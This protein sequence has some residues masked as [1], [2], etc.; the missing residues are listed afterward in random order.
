VNGGWRV[1]T[2]STSPRE[3]RDQGIQCDD[4][5][6]IEYII[7]PPVMAFSNPNQF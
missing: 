3:R 7:S 2:M 6:R 4:D 1:I 5:G